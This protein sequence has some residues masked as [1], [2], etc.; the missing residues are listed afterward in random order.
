ML[1]DDKISQIFNKETYIFKDQD[2][3]D[4]HIHPKN[5]L[6]KENQLH[7][8]AND[9]QPVLK[10]YSPIHTVLLGDFATGKTAAIKR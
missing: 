6:Y 1:S 7:V 9:I 5:L 2:V 8:I 3:F 4:I 10:G